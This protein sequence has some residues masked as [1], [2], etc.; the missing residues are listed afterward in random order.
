MLFPTGL[1]RGSRDNRALDTGQG[2][3][4]DATYEVSDGEKETVGRYLGACKFE[5]PMLERSTT[6]SMC[7]VVFPGVFPNRCFCA[8]PHWIGVDLPYLNIW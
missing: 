5:G 8:P 2:A 1:G 7:V 6:H 4:Q 3:G